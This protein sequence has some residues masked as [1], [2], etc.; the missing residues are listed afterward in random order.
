M[1]SGRQQDIALGVILEDTLLSIFRTVR[2]VELDSHLDR[3][4]FF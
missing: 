3:V 1:I 4:M 2:A